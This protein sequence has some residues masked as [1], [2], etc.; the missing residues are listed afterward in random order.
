MT[1]IDAYKK[2]VQEEVDNYKD[3]LKSISAFI[4]GNPELGLKEYKACERLTSEIEAF[5]FKVE[6]PVAGLETGFVAT[7]KGKRKGPK[8]AFV[9]EYD[10]VPGLGH[11]CGHNIIASSS[12]GAALS[13]K[14]VIS[15]LG[16]TVVLYGTPDEEAVDIQSRGG[17]VIMV[18]A[19]F[20]N[21]VDA[22]LMI[23][24]TGGANSTWRYSFP[25]KDFSIRYVGKPAHYTVPHK[26]I[27]ALES[28]LLFLD[29]VN[30][31]KRGWPPG[32]MFAYTITDGGGPSAITVPKSAQAH[33]T[34]KAFYA[35]YLEQLY[36]KVEACA[37][38]VASL[39]GAKVEIQVL[40][41]YKNMIPNL[42]LAF[43]LFKNM[44][45][46]GAKVEDPF[47][48][49]RNLERRSY[50]GG[51]TDLGDVSW[52]APSIHGYCSIG[53]NDLVAH[54]PEF[55]DAAGSERGH[56]AAILSAKALAMTAVEIVADAEFA[57]KIRAEFQGQKAEGFVNV[58][59]IP[60]HYSPFP[61][62]LLKEF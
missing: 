59:G 53:G 54:T 37:R 61:R 32:V 24:P 46:L 10:S 39:T 22:V 21:D 31:L 27:N 23:H 56:E 51:S 11:A 5:G 2:I 60:P 35:E 14:K 9:A 43:S 40:G 13:L 44:R 6:K 7:Y 52:V 3:K 55:A 36:D 18:E 34:M 25:L 57:K 1:S 19:G 38:S 48:S 49:Q 62:E 58:P 29:T 30:A 50:P 42:K 41:E 16:G 28:L 26:G 4:H 15:E 45:R 20:F 8:I 17:K 47:T 33:I 12:F